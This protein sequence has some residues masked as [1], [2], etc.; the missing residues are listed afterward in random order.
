MANKTPDEVYN[1]NFQDLLKKFEE[2]MKSPQKDSFDKLAEKARITSPLSCRQM[3]AILDRC[4]Y[5]KEQLLNPTIKK[6]G[7]SAYIKSLT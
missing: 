4:K 6:D 7:R 5:Q 2:I 3:E 1:N